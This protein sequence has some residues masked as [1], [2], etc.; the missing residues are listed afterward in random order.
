MNRLDTSS[1]WLCKT[2]WNSKTEFWLTTPLQHLSYTIFRKTSRSFTVDLPIHTHTRVKPDEILSYVLPHE[3]QK[4]DS[5]GESRP[6]VT[7]PKHNCLNLF[8]FQTTPTSQTCN[9]AF[10]GKTDRASVR[11]HVTSSALSIMHEETPRD[12]E[13]DTAEA[14]DTRQPW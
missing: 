1:H 10:G 8:I 11:I 14:D 4:Y 5:K 3:F 13:R 9:S 6:A 7:V 2:L 12:H